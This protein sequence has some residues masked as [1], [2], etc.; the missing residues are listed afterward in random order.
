MC[1]AMNKRTVRQGNPA[2]AVAYLRVSTDEQALGLEAQRT[3]IETWA[4]DRGVTIEAWCID[5]GI[6]GGAALEARPELARALVLLREHRAGVLVVAQRDRLARDVIGAAMVEKLAA[7]VGAVILSVA[8]EG[9]DYTNDPS[10]QLLR[11]MIDAFA[12]YE[13]VMI[14]IRT[15]NAL[16]AKRSRGEVIGGVPPWG[17][18]LSEDRQSWVPDERE[19]QMLA[20]VRE[21]RAQGHGVRPIARELDAAGFRTRNGRK[22][23]HSS[24]VRMLQAMDRDRAAA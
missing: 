6:S 7:N 11:R 20:L 5:E 9:S 16:A 22:V 17:F 2:L 12:E 8:S 21:L 4:G 18:R 19:Q 10:A 1:S 14:A 23:V 15:R 3:S 24:V 13:R